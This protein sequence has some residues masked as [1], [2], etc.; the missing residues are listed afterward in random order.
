MRKVL[1]LAA[2]AFLIPGAVSAQST[3]N[4]PN[5]NQP[6]SSTTT[7]AQSGMGDTGNPMASDTHMQQGDS[8]SNSASTPGSS[9]DSASSAPSAG[10]AGM[11][12]GSSTTGSAMSQGSSAAGDMSSPSGSMNKAYPV[13]S[14]TVK[15]SCRNRGGK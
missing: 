8:M 4:D 15:D 13:C 3:V 5:A 12:A 9:A 10:D 1:L 11:D 7:N 2:A 14:R 6:Q